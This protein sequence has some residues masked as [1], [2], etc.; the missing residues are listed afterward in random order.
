MT[1]STIL[2]ARNIVK[3]YPGVIALDS[4]S[5][6]FRKGEVHALLGENGAGKSTFIKVLTGAIQPEQGH[7]E[8]EG[9]SYPHFT[10]HQA[11][12]LGIAGIY[13]EFNLVPYLT[14]AE[15]IFLGKE[16]TRKTLTQVDEMC[17]KSEEAF[18]VLNI[19][20]NPRV[21]VK[22]LSVAYKQIVEIAKAVVQNAKVVIF[23]EPTA[24]LTN[25]EIKSLFTFIKTLQAQNVA[26]IYI[27]HRLEELFEIA[28]RVSVMRDG[29]H[30]ATLDVAA[31]H[32]KE[33]IKLM[34]GRELGETYPKKPN[35]HDDILL[36]VKNLTSKS[37][38]QNIEFTL[39]KGEILGFG[40]LVGAGR[41]EVARAIF[42]AD[43][44]ETCE[45]AVNGKRVR[46]TSPKQAIRNGLGL[47]PEDRKEQG[48]LLGLSVKENISFSFL[49]KICRWSLIHRKKEQQLAET[50]RQKMNIR[51]PSLE[52]KVKNLSGGNQ[53]KV[54]L[55]RWL[56]GNCQILIFDE[57]TRGIDVGAKQEIYD[58][59]VQ[60]AEAGKGIILISSDMPELLGMSDRI[61]VMHEG[62][63]VGSFLQEH[64]TQD[65]ILELASGIAQPRHGG[66]T[67]S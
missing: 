63:I 24:A 12:E 2:A 11:M 4:V 25:N 45:L 13:Q 57:P 20:I 15:N 59:I 48:V 35:T 33:L 23:D 49:R 36:H 10:P 26:V 18:N 51:T 47:I 6:E 14:V 44:V 39:K 27:S 64:A 31:T 54:A 9:R 53:Q 61:L 46:N 17:R 29:Q 60:L 65:G 3:V 5:V 56:A 52:Q 41:T 38:L 16:I 28:D 62:R 55:A 42:G 8:F 22:N 58:L 43:P 34:V 37:G 40:G 19:H 21:Q 1:G 67:T 66:L 32:E 30:V 7:I 50:F